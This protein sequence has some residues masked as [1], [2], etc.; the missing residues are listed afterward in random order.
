MKQLLTR[1]SL[2]LFIAFTITQAYAAGDK[3]ETKGRVIAAEVKAASLSGKYF[4]PYGLFTKTTDEKS[5][6]IVKGL[7]DSFAILALDKSSLQTLLQSK[8]Q[9]IKLIVPGYGSMPIEMLLYKHDIASPDFTITT[10]SGITYSAE[11]AGGLHYWGIVNNDQGSLAAISF[12]NDDVMGIIATDYGNLNLGKLNG[13]DR[14]IIFNDLQLKEKS[15]F[16]CGNNYATEHQQQPQHNNGNGNRASKCIRFYWEANYDLY[17]QKQSIAATTNFATGLFNQSQILFANDGIN[18]TLSGLK[19]WNTQSPYNVSN[20]TT[21]LNTFQANLPLFNGDLA[22]LIGSSSSI[23]GGLAA[24]VGGLCGPV[25]RRK[26]VSGLNGLYAILPIYSWNVTVVSHEQGHLLGSDHTHACVWNGNNTAIDG[27]GPYYDSGVSY[28]GNCSGAPIPAPVVGG[29]IMSYCH[30]GPA[31]IRLNNGFGPQPANRIINAINNASCLA[32]CTVCTPPANDRCTGATLIEDNTSC[33]YTPGTLNC[34]TEDMLPQEVSCTPFPSLS[35]GVFYHFYAKSNKVNI[36][37]IP[38][39][40]TTTGLDAIAVLYS[41]SSCNDLTEVAG[42]CSDQFNAGQTEKMIVNVFPG[43]HYWLWINHWQD[44]YTNT[45]NRAFNVCVSHADTAICTAPLSCVSSSAGVSA[46]VLSCY[47]SQGSGGSLQ[48]KWYKGTDCSGT[49]LGTDSFYNATTAGTYTCK[50]YISGHESECYNCSSGKATLNVTECTGPKAYITSINGSLNCN[51]TGSTGSLRYKWYKGGNCTG[52]ELITGKVYDPGRSGIYS[53]KVY[54]Y[55]R[56]AT[57]YTCAQALAKSTTDIFMAHSAAYTVCSGLF[58]DGGGGYDDYFENQD[59]TITIYPETPGSKVSVRF[60]HFRTQTTYNSPYSPGDPIDDILYVYNG[61]STA[62]PQI[63]L[64]TGSL[65][66]TVTST[67]ADGSL[68]FRFVSHSPYYS[69]GSDIRSGWTGVIT[70]ETSDFYNL[71]MTASGTISTCKRKFY[72]SGGPTKDYMNNQREIMPDTGVVITVYPDSIGG[73]MTVAFDSFITQSNYISE[74]NTLLRDTDILYIYNGNSTSAPV[75]AKLYDD[76]AVPFSYTSTAA[77]GS[78]TFKFTSARSYANYNN[79]RGWIA[80]LSC[81]NLLSA[82]EEIDAG[83]QITAYPNPAGELL[84]IAGHGIP[85]CSL[86]ISLT[87]VYGNLIDKTAL[88]G[89]GSGF[90]TAFDTGKIA[91]GIY[92]V[93]VLGNGINHVMKVHKE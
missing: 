9:F 8:P 44:A 90:N 49:V 77:D 68:T 62:A 27:C 11:E 61:N 41:G 10:S 45:G 4:A 79:R 14:F 12:F 72:D 65:Y 67:A 81:G 91:A 82:G 50:A 54:V 7:T 70:C 57:C 93:T 22:H 30:L 58:L 1:L 89:G 35:Y 37:V 56:E 55:G 59:D 63:G 80:N 18:I 66:G 51:S 24:G 52:D 71:H 23:A 15:N 28:E 31:G 38:D 64:M 75:L 26:C 40:K 6:G 13:S 33:M 83:L 34:A 20:K 2:L 5:A 84:N 48:Y 46:A 76:P 60:T 87:D 21:F 16:S 19:I 43:T 73:R 78:L 47:S 17:Q 74:N 53:C 69:P 29:T 86:S 25:S 36:E 92:F 39:D 3:Q 85:D 32:T 42:G 88:Q